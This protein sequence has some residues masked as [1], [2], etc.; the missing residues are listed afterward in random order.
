MTTRAGDDHET[1]VGVVLEAWLASCVDVVAPTDLDRLRRTVA[2]LIRLAG[3]GANV[4]ELRIVAAAR[5]AAGA[6][7]VTS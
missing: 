5:L 2:E 1:L 6:S 7:R 3:E 4:Q